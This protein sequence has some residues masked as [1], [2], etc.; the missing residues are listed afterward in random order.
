MDMPAPIKA[1]FEADR[2]PDGAPPL[3]AFSDE[4]IVIDE[5]R[6]HSGLAAIDAWWRT[7]KAQF[8]HT[9]TPLDIAEGA[10]TTIVHARVSGS[11]SG[12]PAELRFAFTLDGGTIAKLEIRP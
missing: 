1:F 6:T 12:S 2:T 9:T 10:E 8:R 11:F 5:A 3:G 7:A 4:S